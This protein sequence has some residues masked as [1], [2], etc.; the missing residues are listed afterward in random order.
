MAAISINS[1]GTAYTQNFNTLANTG[2]SST[3]PD[4]WEFLET[5][6]NANSTY[7][8]GTGSSNAGDTYSFGRVAADRALGTL[9][10]GNLIPI[11]GAS[12]TNNTGATITSLQIS[13]RGEQW[14][15]GTASRADRLDF[16]YSFDATSLS[17][18]TWT[19]FNALDFSTPNTATTGAK[20]GKLICI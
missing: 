11:I 12:F 19:D 13:Y 20:D 15:S 6:A 5:G 14:R 18:G 2:T 1:G 7:T 17:N 9:R 4:G 10:S 8:A 16:Q 3:L